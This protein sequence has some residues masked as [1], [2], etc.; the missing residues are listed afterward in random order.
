MRAK[1]VVPTDGELAALDERLF[2]GIS[3][4][5]RSEAQRDRDRVLYSSAFQRLGHVTQVTASETGLSF[6]SRLT[7]SLKVAQFARRFAERLKGSSFDGAAARAVEA[8]D[9]DAAEAAALAHDLGHPPFGHLAEQA[10]NKAAHGFGGFEGNAQSFR[11]L[12][13]LALR[14]Q[15]HLGLNLTRRTLNGVLKYP[16]LRNHD[17]DRRS[18]KWNVYEADKK[19]F[20]WARGARESD[21]K[22]LEAEIMDWADDVTYAVHDMDDFY[23]AGLVPLD[24]LCREKS[25]LEAF[26]DYLLEKNPAAGQEQAAAAED[27]FSGFFN[28]GSPY[29]GAAEERITLR[30]TGSGL[31][32]RYMDAPTVDCG[33]RAG[34]AF[35]VIDE[36]I[37]R[38]VDV[39][40]QLIWFYVIERP[41]LAILQSGQTRIITG[42]YEM[43]EEAA[44]GGDLRLFPV[45]YRERLGT[46]ETRDAK[47]RVIVDLISSLTEA[48]AVEIYHRMTGVSA[49]SVGDATGRLA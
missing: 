16:W 5:T 36:N 3:P 39:L 17:V 22:T 34:E 41:S 25:E 26:Q 2:G 7:H 47:R 12:T 30:A 35:F 21:H 43:Y 29:S 24:R 46:A 49:G 42:L 31:I 44:I 18:K 38:Q 1:L 40:K 28:F 37:K 9:P 11:I 33:A 8:L 14:S 6:H 15:E 45:L 27:L 10:L 13:R 23:R 4:F 48:G 19:V 32:T 20:E